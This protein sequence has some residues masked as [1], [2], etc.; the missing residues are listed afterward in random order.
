MNAS[1]ARGFSL[2]IFLPDGAPEGLRL[3]EKSN[4]TGHGLVCPRTRF[5]DARHRSEFARTGV[6]VL[7]G[8]SEDGDLPTVYNGEGDPALPRLDSHF[9]EKDFWT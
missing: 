1:P 8:P 3:I 5:K 9:A 7:V 6:Y 4:W 2:R